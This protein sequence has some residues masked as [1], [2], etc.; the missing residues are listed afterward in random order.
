MFKTGIHFI[1]GFSQLLLLLPL[2]PVGI[3]L[4]RRIYHS[5]L[6]L[7]LSS[8]CL[9]QLVPLLLFQIITTTDRG[10]NSV[11]NI[12]SLIE[13]L[14]YLQIFRV[15]F[16]KTM[17]KWLDI[18]VIALLA[19]ILTYFIMRGTGQFNKNLNLLQNGF[20]VVLI[21]AG[22]PSLV[23]LFDLRIF[24]S[25][26][27]WISAGTLFYLLIWLLVASTSTGPPQPQSGDIKEWDKAVIINTASFV[28]YV[29]YCFSALVYKSSTHHKNR[30]VS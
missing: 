12:F 25:A 28:R 27:F 8:L 1:D 6:F 2:L 15:F 9:V 16:N 21:L 24:Q 7:L 17:R 20:V 23:K 19:A 18:I 22:L 30:G 3:V 5:D 11:L 4:F 13:L 10:K 29:F 26:L 14:I